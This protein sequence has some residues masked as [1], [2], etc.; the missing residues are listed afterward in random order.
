MDDLTL[1]RALHVLAIV[2]W[3]GGVALVT[4]VILPA[5][6]R[7]TDAPGRLAAFEAIEGRFSRQ[8]RVSV[9]IAGLSG[10]WMTERLDAW[11]RFAD[12]GFWWMHAMALVWVVF[13]IV[14]Y[15]AEPLYL[16]RWFHARAER[17]PEGTFALVTRL[18][19]VLL[20]A[21]AATVLAAVL[22]AHGALAAQD[23]ASGFAKLIT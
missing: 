3:I 14:L 10:F 22:G 2:H 15:V 16:H 18:H 5:V 12:P 13:A 4:L 23:G 7:M 6:R 8:A 9:A 19:R 11:H 21:S 1:A 20:A 17:D